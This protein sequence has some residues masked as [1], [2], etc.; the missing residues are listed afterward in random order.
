M[1]HLRCQPGNHASSE[2][3][4]DENEVAKS[5]FG[6]VVSYRGNTVIVSDIAIG[7]RAMPCHRRVVDFV[8][9]GAQF[10]RDICP[11]SS[12]VPGAV[13]KNIDRHHKYFLSETISGVSSGPARTAG[14]SG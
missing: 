4:A 13:D 6:D 8:A 14:Q 11:S 12:V 3:V 1:W 7:A 10:V 2:A 5:V 9:Q